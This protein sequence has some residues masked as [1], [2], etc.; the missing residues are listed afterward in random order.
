[1][2]FDIL[3]LAGAAAELFFFLLLTLFA[4]ERRTPALAPVIP[5]GSEG[6]NSAAEKGQDQDEYDYPGKARHRGSLAKKSEVGSYSGFVFFRAVSW[7][8]FRF[9]ANYEFDEKPLISMNL[10]LNK[11]NIE[12]KNIETVAP[13][14]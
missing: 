6:K 5:D 1:M 10:K 9:P 11:L 2:G 7:S 14:N 12:R 3:Y 4:G 13:L 8:V